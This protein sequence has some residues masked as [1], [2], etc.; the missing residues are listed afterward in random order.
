MRAIPKADIEMMRED[1]YERTGKVP[2][3]KFKKY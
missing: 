1:E 2:N 3:R